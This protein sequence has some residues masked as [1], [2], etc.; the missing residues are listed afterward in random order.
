M[1]DFM[2][3]FADLIQANVPGRMLVSIAAGCFVGFVA[4]RLG[5]TSAAPHLGAGT[6]IALYLIFFLRMFRADRSQKEESGRHPRFH[7]VVLLV[8]GALTLML[9]ILGWFMWTSHMGTIFLSHEMERGLA[10]LVLIGVVCVAIGLYLIK[11]KV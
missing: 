7:G 10:M 6:S 11:S 8:V 4:Y 9:L 3:D 1:L 2:S 5:Y